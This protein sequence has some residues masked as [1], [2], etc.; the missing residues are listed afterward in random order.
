M[1]RAGPEPPSTRSRPIRDSGRCPGRR[2]AGPGARLSRSSVGPGGLRGSPTIGRDRCHTGL[3]AYRAVI[4]DPTVDMVILATPPGFRPAHFEAAIAAGK[5]VFMEK[6]AAVD[7]PGVRASWPRPSWPIARAS[8]SWRAPCRRHEACYIAA[9]EGGPIR[10]DRTDRLAHCYWNQ[11]GL[12]VRPR[13]PHQSDL[14]AGPQL[15][16]LRVAL[17]RSHRGAA[18]PQPRRGELGDG[19]PARALHGHGWATGADRSGVRTHLRPLRRRVRVL[20]RPTRHEH[21][22]QIDGCAGRVEERFFGT[23]G[24]LTTARGSR[25]SRAPAVAI[26]GPEP[27]S[28]RQG[29][30]GTLRRD[31]WPADQSGQGC[32]R[33]DAHGDHGTH[34]GLHGQGRDL[35]AGHGQPGGPDPA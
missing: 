21:A 27:Q 2:P 13:E 28:L 20:R 14:G 29:A 17:R 31:P 1:R 7:A 34:V 22:R 35:G 23:S 26:H 30:R 24:R 6:P 9:M 10:Q 25:S 15:A 33:I 5:H 32:R 11:G 16:L 18:R 8:A 3:D 4:D 12:W 19:R